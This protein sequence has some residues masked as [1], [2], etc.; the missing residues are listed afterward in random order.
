MLGS[1]AGPRLRSV[2]SSRNDVFVTSVR[3]S[4]ANPPSDQVAQYGSPEKIW[5]YSLVRRKRTI[6]SLVTSASMTS[7]APASVRVPAAMSRSA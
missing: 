6:R 3:P 1:G 5:S 4:S 7:W 2:W